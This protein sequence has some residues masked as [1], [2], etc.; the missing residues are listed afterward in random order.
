M[1]VPTHQHI[2]SQG[3]HLETM[4]FLY[5]GA[6]GLGADTT[7]TVFETATMSALI[8][9]TGSGLANEGNVL[10]Y[11]RNDRNI[12]DSNESGY[13]SLKYFHT[14]CTAKPFQDTASV[15][16]GEMGYWQNDDEQYPTGFP[17]GVTYTWDQG[18]T[19]VS[20]VA[21]ATLA[22]MRYDTIGFLQ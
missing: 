21:A 10:G 1:T 12:F 7:R 20:S 8:A 15:H 2:I 9:S 6:S 14:R 19:A 22:V 3:V 13:N 4:L 11:L 16:H 18:G 5:W 17:A